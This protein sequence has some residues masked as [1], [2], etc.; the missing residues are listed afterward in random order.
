MLAA[1]NER[2]RRELFEIG[3]VT[4]SAHHDP[5]SLNDIQ[6]AQKESEL[7]ARPAGA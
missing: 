6:P 1:Y 3:S 2:R 7:F 4:A 5:K